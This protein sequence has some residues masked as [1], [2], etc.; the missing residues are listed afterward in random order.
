MLAPV[1]T[2]RRALPRDGLA[3]PLF[4]N[5]ALEAA[6]DH[7]AWADLRFRAVAPAHAMVCKGPDLPGS[8]SSHR[9]RPQHFMHAGSLPSFGTPDLPAPRCACP[10]PA[11]LL[12]TRS[13]GWRLLDARALIRLNDR[14]TPPM[15]PLHQP[16]H[17]PPH[18]PLHQ[19]LHQHTS[20]PPPA[21][22]QV[23]S[24]GRRASPMQL[25]HISTP[26]VDIASAVCASA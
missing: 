3:G 24:R 21:C 9:T 16:M 4:W 13:L 2:P 10:H 15:H 8:L 5:A 23:R 25:N 17:Q 1:P 11:W 12:P 6:S 22:S 14:H 7:H 20:P 18:Q 26:H 19:P